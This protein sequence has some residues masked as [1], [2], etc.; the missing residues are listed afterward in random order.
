MEST[1]FANYLYNELN[2]FFQK[3]TVLLYFAPLVEVMPDGNNNYKSSS[4]DETLK[5]LIK[6]IKDKNIY[7]EPL[8]VNL[9][10]TN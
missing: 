4:S 7:K 5:N 3:S 2:T 10:P 1:I 8:P 6:F 9:P